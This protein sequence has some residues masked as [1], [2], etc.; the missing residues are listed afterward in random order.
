MS[1]HATYKLSEDGQSPQVEEVIDDTKNQNIAD[2]GETA[3]I[4]TDKEMSVIESDSVSTDEH[5]AA[6]S[7][8]QTWGAQLRE[9]REKMA[10]SRGEAADRLFLAVSII[11]AL[12]AED[13]HSLPP[14]SYVQGYLRS[15]A[16][17]LNLSPEPLIDSYKRQ[18]ANENPALLGQ[19]RHV[20]GDTKLST[21]S[22]FIKITTALIIIGVLT[23]AVWGWQQ[24][25][26]DYFLPSI[27]STPATI[28]TPE[29]NTSITVVP[30]PES[31]PLAPEA[32]VTDDSPVLPP[33]VEPDL[34]P[35]A[36]EDAPIEEATLTESDERAQLTEAVE[37]ESAPENVESNIILQVETLPDISDANSVIL[38][39]RGESWLEVHDA[40]EKQLLYSLHPGGE[41]I[42]LKGE[43]P[44]KLSI[45]R[46]DA[47]T[48]KYAGDIVD[49]SAYAGRVANITLGATS[50]E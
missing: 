12:E 11:E 36:N 2:T 42:V 8:H 9:G 41:T 5:T 48:V 16:R 27:T 29:S 18:N 37:N 17:F 50:V 6:E 13:Y 28:E 23:L 22:L 1:E 43:P 7:R 47:I 31:L 39:I 15:Y 40:N 46:P 10:L 32:R 4:A 34:P 35:V 20:P 30:T 33:V 21:N 38:Q 25:A 24:G 14:D 49:L 26:P 19:I 45:G 3:D 44:F